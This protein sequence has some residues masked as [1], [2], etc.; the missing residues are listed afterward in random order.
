MDMAVAAA[1]GSLG[2]ADLF[3]VGGA[4][5]CASQWFNNTYDH[6]DY[7]D[8]VSG[9]IY[10]LSGGQ[11]PNAA[12]ETFVLRGAVPPPTVPVPAALPLLASGLA[13]VFGVARRRAR[14]V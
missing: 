14:T 13:L 12:E 11:A 2:W 7:D 6:C 9:Y 4:V 5:A 8:A 3:V 1:G 10:N